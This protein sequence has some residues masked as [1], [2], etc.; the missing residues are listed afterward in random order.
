MNSFLRGVLIFLLLVVAFFLL[1]VLF[2][3][4]YCNCCQRLRHVPP[5]PKQGEVSSAPV[6]PATA[7]PQHP[8]GKY[9]PFQVPKE[10]FN[11]D[12]PRV[13][14]TGPQRGT[15]APSVQGSKLLQIQKGKPA[16]W[17]G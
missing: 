3:L 16:R 7:Q 13:V 4:F 8:R 17:R 10:G 6:N 5:G 9:P 14:P 15:L 12:H 11:E 1:G 2:W